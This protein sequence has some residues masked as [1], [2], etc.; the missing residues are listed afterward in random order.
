M[1]HLIN[2]DGNSDLKTRVFP[3]AKGI[4]KHLI[5]TLNNYNGDKTIEG[6]KRLNNLISMKNGIT[7]SEMKRLKNFFDNYQGTNKSMEYILNGGEPMKLWVNNTLYTAT[8][9]VRDFKQAKSDAGM[10]NAFRKPHEKDRQTKRK[11]KPTQVQFKTNDVNKG[12]KNNSLL[13]FETIL[14][15]SDWHEYYDVMY[16]YG[17]SY[18]LS[19]FLENPQGKQKWLPLINP[20]MYQKAL[21]EFTKYG[22]LQNFPSKYIYQWM[23]IIMRNTAQLHAN[24]ELA[25]HMQYF[26]YEEFSEF[27]EAYFGNDDWEIKNDNVCYVDEDGE[28]I[29]TNI[30]DFCDEIGLYD[31]MEAPDG[32]SA[33]S[34]YGLEPIEKLIAEYN[35]NKTPEEVLVIINKILDVYHCRGDLSS[36]FI[37][38]GTKSLY[39]V[40]N[41]VVENKKK[42]ICITEAQQKLILKY[43]NE[44]QNDV[45]SLETLSSLN[46]FKKRYE[47]C[48]QNVGKPQGKGSSRVCFQLSD[49]KILKLAYND[50]GIAQNNQ[51]YD[52]YLD[53]LGIVPHTYDI[54]RN[55]L[56]IISEYVLPAKT[57][58]F[59]HCLNMS[60]KDFCKFIDTCHMWRFDSPKA[61][62]LSETGDI[63]TIEEYDYILENNEDLAPFD[64]Y[65]GN[66]NPP[67]GDLKAIRN[68]GMTMRYGY[69]TIVIL[70]TGL[71]EEIYDTYYNKRK[72]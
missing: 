35:E 56:W 22:K 37:Q 67:I 20:S 48:V 60:F 54:D 3:L 44:A 11:N 52:G 13:K 34:D 39:Q 32:S 57:A 25:G 6:Y 19:T 10:S 59:K 49:D 42:T 62:S 4:K 36:L 70:D 24:T 15:E 38:G 41:G 33:W 1:I 23:G 12:I 72:K 63:M 53:D 69:P 28:K 8:K 46:S 5:Q 55:G 9:A 7:Y 31:W 43:L 30:F 68:Y 17:L 29:E 27:L 2:E 21:S 71:S 65:I 58:D 50:K 14:R 16:E 40:S 64:D 18:V 47:Y 26:P 61:K 51:E 66:Y 45:F